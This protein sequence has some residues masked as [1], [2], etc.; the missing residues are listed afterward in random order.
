MTTV[1]RTIIDGRNVLSTTC[2][3]EELSLLLPT[4]PLTSC[5]IIEGYTQPYV[6]V[7]T[8]DLGNKGKN[9]VR[10]DGVLVLECFATIPHPTLFQYEHKH[11]N[12]ASLGQCLAWS[13]VP[14][15]RAL[16]LYPSYAKCAILERWTP[17]FDLF[18]GCLET[19][20]QQQDETFEHRNFIF[21]S[22]ANMLYDG[23]PLFNLCKQKAMVLVNVNVT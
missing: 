13:V 17:R 2:T 22:S 23:Q 5:D 4:L 11:L 18:Y 8:Y 3:Q 6:I 9:I 20:N 19:D 14:Y 1:A 7:E 21:L 15:D 12:W 10:V 16:Y